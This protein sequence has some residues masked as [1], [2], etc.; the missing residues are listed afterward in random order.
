MTPP[1]P[2]RKTGVCSSLNYDYI[3]R[4]SDAGQKEEK[5]NSRKGFQVLHE[6]IRRVFSTEVF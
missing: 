4:D 2:R 3:I 6:V 5:R 1:N